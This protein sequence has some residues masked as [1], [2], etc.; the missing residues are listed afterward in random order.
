MLWWV[1]HF[2]PPNLL[3]SELPAPRSDVSGLKSTTC[4]QIRLQHRHIQGIVG[5]GTLRGGHL[6][7]FRAKIS[8]STVAVHD[9]QW[10]IWKI[11]KCSLESWRNKQPAPNKS[12]RMIP[13]SVLKTDH[14]ENSQVMDPILGN[15]R[16]TPSSKFTMC[17][18]AAR[19]QPL[20]WKTQV[21]MGQNLMNKSKCDQHWS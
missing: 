10:V 7:R 16:T 14:F 12:W 6:W 5:H 2:Q 21:W 18:P 17:R 15:P 1:W 13:S 3:P 11:Q 20:F 9:L 19:L 8:P 4:P